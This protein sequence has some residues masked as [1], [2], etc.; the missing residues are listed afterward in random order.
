M[1]KII[2]CMD[3]KDGRVVKGVKFEGLSDVSSPV[4]LAK[5]YNTS[6]ADELVFYDITASN[7]GRK[8]FSEVLT[9]VSK[10]VGIPLIIGG[11]I[12]TIEDFDKSFELGASKVSINTG[13]LK[14]PKIIKEAAQKY[15]SERVILSIDAKKVDGSY[16]VYTSGGMKD[17]GLELTE[18]VKQGV[19]LGAGELVINSIDT[20]GVKGGF[21]LEMLQAVINVTDVPIIASGGAGKIEDFIE[22]F[23]KLPEISAGL[24]ASVFHFGEV[25]IM[26]LK[27]ELQKNDI[28]VAL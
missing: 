2:P 9:E 18:W 4:E 3:V 20:D 27:K 16:R 21:D 10:C 13:A 15:R 14:N 19:E 26:E 6:G 23:K 8:A 25:N 12:S 28:P 5:A 17:A 24:A 1:K 22:L 11:G 7:E